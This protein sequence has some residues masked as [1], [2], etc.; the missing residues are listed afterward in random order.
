VIIS[1][2]QEYKFTESQHDY[3]TGIGIIYKGRETL[4]EIEKFKNNYDKDRDC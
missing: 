4:M 1:V 3:R 2:G